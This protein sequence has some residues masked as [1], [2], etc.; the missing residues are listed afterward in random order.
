M[1]DRLF[2]L[3]TPCP[4]GFKFCSELM[5]RDFRRSPFALFAP[6]SEAAREF[7]GHLLSRLAGVILIPGDHYFSEEVTPLVSQIIIPS[8]MLPFL[9]DFAAQQL[10]QLDRLI[11]SEERCSYLTL[12]NKRYELNSQRASEEF[13]RFRTSLLHEIEE[14]RAAETALRES[15]RRSRA[16]FDQTYQLTGLLALDGTLIE[17]NRASLGLVGAENVIGKPF[18]ETP[19]WTHSPELQEKLRAA[20]KKAAN[21][22]FVRFEATHPAADG[23]LHY[24]DFS[25]KPVTD[26]TGKVVLLIPE[27]RD[28]TERK[29]AE[30]ELEFKNLILSTQQE[31]SID[32]ILVVDESNIIISCNRRFIELWEIPSELV[33]TRNNAPVLQLVTTKV[34]DMEGFAARVKYLYD[35][36]EEKSREELFL[37]DGRVFDRYSAPVRGDDGKYYGRIWYFRDITE[38]KRMEEALRES[39]ERYRA[40]VELSPDA[41]Y[42]HTGGKLIF[43]NREGAKLLGVDRPED[44]YG[45]EALDFVHPDSLESV[46][47][48]IA[49]AFRT[50]EP[51]P[52]GEQLYVRTDGSQVPV[53]VASVPFKYQGENALLVIVRDTTERRRMQEELLKGQKLESLGLLAGGIAHNFNNLLTGIV[54]NLSIAKLL[55]DP[56]HKIA[57][58]LE[59]CEKAAIR[60][61]EL[62]QQLLTFA[63]GGE[64][65]KKLINPESLIRETVSFTMRG[66]NIRNIIDIQDNLW[67]MEVDESQLSQVLNNLLLN[68][69][70]AMPAGGEVTIRAA[71]EALLNDS[72]YKLPQGNYIRIDVED[73]G[74]GIPRENLL[75]IFDPYFTTKPKGSGLGLA[76]VYS[77][78]KR[79]GGAVEVSS[80]LGAGATFSIHLPATPHRLPE[81]TGTSESLELRGSGR[82][83]VM[84]DEDMIREIA[85][86]ILEF[87]GYEVDCCV[88]GQEAVEHFRAAREK[89]VPYSA[90]IL[91]LT[92]PGGMG[93][94][95]AAARI[96]EIDPDAVLIVS[97]GYSSDPVIA[98]FSQYGFSGVVPKPFDAGGLAR[99][100][101]RLI[102][103]NC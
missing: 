15:E 98:N 101:K 76:S 58:R 62:T 9:A 55:L 31:T 46:R 97:S 72:P 18:W 103:T 63:R 19:W 47:Q 26:E 51:N 33:E 3:C 102:P 16:I 77:I 42:I 17:A 12:E 14:R 71:N 86:H 59:Q 74:C 68:A 81:D 84:D 75:R 45:R 94:K 100:L 49:K 6:S 57:N 2:S 25:L 56:S 7:L 50:G 20:V 67:S 44:L 53:E 93:G 35:H 80:T 64:P 87:M 73:R 24:V 28:I 88:D 89:N 29:Q 38:R 34:T 54:G 1:N 70:Q 79:H 41:I 22:E 95:E 4:D 52:Q 30:Q 92:I 40:L 13:S 5:V 66:A 90:V 96:L 61:T 69:S 11:G 60:A 43:A 78:V 23:N 65:V 85:T 91:D 99:E 36:R 39:E 83:L 32:G 10:L 8:P 37:K 82:V 27:G 21:G 48:R